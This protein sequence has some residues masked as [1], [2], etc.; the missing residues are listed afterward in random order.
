[1]YA[2]E[3]SNSAER[4]LKILTP[5]AQD[6]IYDVIEELR[7]NPRHRGVEKLFSTSK[8]QEYRVRV[9]KYRIIFSI[10]DNVLLIF[11]IKIGLRKKVYQ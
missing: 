6:R 4:E 2:V 9:G 8:S 7:E 5:E 11:V 10:N 3:Y 1:M